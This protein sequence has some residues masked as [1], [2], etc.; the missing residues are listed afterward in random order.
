MPPRE[1]QDSAH[2]AQGFGSDIWSPLTIVMSR[3]I[4]FTIRFRPISDRE[5]KSI[6]AA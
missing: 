1:E 2:G 3:L 5:G 6:H 4:S